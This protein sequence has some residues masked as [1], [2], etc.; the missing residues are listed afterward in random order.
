MLSNL[1]ITDNNDW[2]IGKEAQINGSDIP[3]N[4]EMEEAYGRYKR[5]IE[6]FLN[7]VKKV[8]EDNA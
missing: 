3:P 5:L 7:S 1:V 8:G 4:Y 6:P 2:Y